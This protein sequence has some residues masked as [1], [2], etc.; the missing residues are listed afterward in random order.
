MAG[1]P[2]IG[3]VFALALN[4]RIPVGIPAVTLQLA[5]GPT[6]IDLEWEAR[7][8]RFAWMRQPIPSLGRV[9]DRLDELASALGV[10]ERDITTTK[11]PVQEASSGVPFLYVPLA[12]R[13]AVNRAA[14]DRTRV[15]TFFD[16]HQHAELPVFVFSLEAGEDDATV[17]SRMFAPLFGV[18]EDPATGGA[19]GPLGA[20]LLRHGAVSPEQATHMMS[21]QGVAMNRPSRVFISVASE[22]GAIS[23]VR[24]GGTSVAVGRGFLEIQEDDD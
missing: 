14:L 9:F 16:A 15:R 18:A 21:F 13:R 4:G 23:S 1:H 5:V 11:L 3:T 12:T 20:Y 22:G 24:V 6:P 2:T 10:D 7:Q 17:F 19:S 8:L